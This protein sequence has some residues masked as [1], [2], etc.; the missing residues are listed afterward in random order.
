MQSITDIT[1]SAI[2]KTA[3]HEITHYIA[4]SGTQTYSLLEDYVLSRFT[5]Q[6]GEKS[7][8][9]RIEDIQE[10]YKD[11]VGKRAYPRT[12]KGRNGGRR[13]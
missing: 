6:Y 3:S 8:D 1:G 2:L 11:Q 12:G 13:L 5:E 9:N 7:V 4:A 10:Q